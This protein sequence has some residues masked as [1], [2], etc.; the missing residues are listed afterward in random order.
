MS[1]LLLRNAQNLLLC[2]KEFQKLQEKD[3]T[4]QFDEA[5]DSLKSVA[6]LVSVASH[7]SFFPLMCFPRFLLQSVI[8]DPDN[9]E[10]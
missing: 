9:S 4:T 8:E 10:E 7:I 3:Q 5:K 2:C 1:M 6:N